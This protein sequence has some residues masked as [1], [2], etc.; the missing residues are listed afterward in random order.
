MIMKKGWIIA[1]ILLAVL[2]AAF[3][4]FSLNIT[5]KAVFNNF[6][7][8]S[9]ICSANFQAYESNIG[10]ISSEQNCLAAYQKNK[11]KILRDLCANS[12]T[13]GDIDISFGKKKIAG[14]PIECDE[15]L[16]DENIPVTFTGEYNIIT[17]DDF[18]AGTST[19]FSIIENIDIGKSYVLKEINGENFPAFNPGDII[20]VRGLKKG[21]SIVLLYKDERSSAKV[22]GSSK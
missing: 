12:D 1:I 11:D 15:K 14:I 22:S 2:G 10:K 9:Q 19:A 7:K 18:E 8:P 3:L 5:G 16:A 21:N 17:T 6:F 13:L 4:F 20:K